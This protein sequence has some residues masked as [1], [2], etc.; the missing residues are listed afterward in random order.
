MTAASS[1]TGFKDL[2]LLFV[3]QA[4]RKVCIC[5]NLEQ[6]R[7]MRFALLRYRNLDDVCLVSYSH[8]VRHAQK[9]RVVALRLSYKIRQIKLRGKASRLVWPVGSCLTNKRVL[10]VSVPPFFVP[11]GEYGACM[12]VL[13]RGLLSLSSTLWMNAAS[14]SD[15]LAATYSA[16]RSDTVCPVKMFL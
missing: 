3:G 5:K 14:S 8:Y 11:F 4:E 2:W 9:Q 1:I 13:R 6:I 7:G 15:T 12:S 10:C 16:A